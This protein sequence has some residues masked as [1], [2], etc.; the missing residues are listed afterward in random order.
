MKQ[1]LLKAGRLALRDEGGMWV[2][3]YALPNT[4]KDA[5]VLGSVALGAVVDRPARK[6]QFMELMKEVVADLIEQAIGVRPVWP[7]PPEVAPEHER[8]GHA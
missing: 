7:T 1:E 8:G 4:M 5:L 2:A 6:Q 3:Y